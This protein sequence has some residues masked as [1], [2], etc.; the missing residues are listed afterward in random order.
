NELFINNGDLTF[1]ERAEEFGLDDQGV[2]IHASFFDYDK[3]GDLDMYLLNYT[4]QSIGS[5]DL[6]KNHRNKMGF[7]GGD[8]FYRNELVQPDTSA[9]AESPAP[10]TKNPK[11]TDVTEETGIFSSDIGFGLSVSVGDVNR[12]G[13]EDIFISNDFFERDY[14]YIN[15]RDG[16]FREVLEKQMKSISTT[17]MGGDIADLN[18]DGLPEIRSEEHTSELQS[19]F[20]LVC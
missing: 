3:D 9:S 8:R 10:E 13:W 2:S 1:T 6:E 7:K 20:D 15:N 17:S 5:F 4:S 14:L 18:H 11:F 16:T 19:R 12:D